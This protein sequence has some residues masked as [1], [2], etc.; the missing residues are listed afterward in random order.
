VIR[1][2]L[3]PAEVA[4]AA[5]RARRQHDYATRRGFVAKGFGTFG[6][7]FL[8]CQGEA[9]VAKWAGVELDP[10]WTWEA[11][12]ARGYDVAG[13]Q[14]RTRSRARAGLNL[15]RGD[16]GRFLLV[17]GH[18]APVMWLF[19][20]LDAADGFR[21]G[22]RRESGTGDRAWWEVDQKYLRPLDGGVAEQLGGDPGDEPEPEP[23]PVRGLVMPEASPAWTGER[24]ARWLAGGYS[25]MHD[26]G[27]YRA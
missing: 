10:D 16:R 14:V 12:R 5:D 9:A 26:R 2:E 11:D 1:I 17:L 20:W 4:A 21:L 6:T 15:H 25:A 3:D 19:G 22:E 13:W 24:D 27:H 7:H 8:G 18:Q 23:E